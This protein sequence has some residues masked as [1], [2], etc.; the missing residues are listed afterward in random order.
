M[1]K[2]Y[3][4][5]IC[6]ITLIGSLLPMTTTMAETPPPQMLTTEDLLELSLE[7]LMQVKIL[8][9]ATGVE[10]SL[11]KAPAVATVITA[12]D[13]EATGA[14]NVGEVLEMVPG[15]HV[16]KYFIG[17]EPIYTI[18]G[19]Y[20]TYNPH[21]LMLVNGIPTTRLYLGNRGL[22][23]S[24]MSVNNIA[25]IEVIRGPGSAMY[26]ADA[27]AGMINV[28]TK[29]QEEI[30]GTEAGLRLGS[31]D[32]RDGWILQSHKWGEVKIAAALE[33]H[34]TQGP[35]EIIQADMQTALDKLYGTHASL[36]PGSLN[37]QRRDLDAHL[38]LSTGKWQLRLGYQGRRNVEVGTGHAQALDSTARFAE[39]RI[40]TDLT[41][42]DATF[43]EHWD[44]TAQL[45][46]FNAASRPTSNV[47]LYPPGAFKGAYPD[48]YIGNPSIS[49]RH[50]R[51]TLSGFYKGFENH[52]LRMGTGFFYGDLYKIKQVS[53]FGRDPITGKP[54]PPGSGLLDLSDTP[55]AFMSENT[56]QNWHLF[57]Q[58]TYT[59]TPQWELTAGLRYDDYSDFGTTLN[60]RLALVWQ[61][62]P[63][64]TSKLLYGRAFRAPSFYELY[65][66]N[67]PVSLGN[68][69]LQPETIDTLELAFNYRPTEQLQFSTNWFTY[70]MN[71]VIGY[72]ASSQNV[73][74]ATN[75]GTQSGHGVELEMQWQWAKNVSILGNYAF[76]HS[77]D[78]ERDHDIG[79]APHHHVYVRGDWLFQP[80][81]HLDLQ[82]N[83]V[84][85]RQRPLYDPRPPI[86]DYT[87]V[88][89][90]LRYKKS[91]DHWNVGLAVRNLFDT[92]AREPSPGPRPNGAIGIPEDL[93]LAGRH[94]WVEVRYQF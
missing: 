93:P 54:L 76:Q 36:A 50:T 80:H 58:D 37:L 90:T 47:L 9:I 39:D 70:E 2:H 65:A 22:V 35:T 41:Y 11:A 66:V 73:V 89:L 44:V 72:L 28:I 49:E 7:D 45:S 64:L 85:D 42:H 1:K 33:F 55:W 83:W 62:H 77:Q 88:D 92:D 29:N 86:D 5:T 18:R 3:L 59:F 56:R 4:I 48:G 34:D 38:D 23:G 20:L 52:L 16:S 57:V 30:Q 8:T 94:Y 51:F 26:G 81:W 10:Q 60:P 82:A 63:K 17:Y 53:N 84:A 19:I 32:T 91:Q 61:T 6:Y 68:P 40:N 67:N 74:M 71:D 14:T 24:E 78:E 79:Y 87:M 31:F 13:I 21:V 69:Q 12:E 46:V 15:L 75:S 43:T 27:F 25:R